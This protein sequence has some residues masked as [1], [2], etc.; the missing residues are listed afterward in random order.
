[1]H[2]GIRI[3]RVSRKCIKPSS[4][5]KAGSG[6]REYQVVADGSVPCIHVPILTFLKQ[7]MLYCIMELF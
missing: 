4:L 7:S 3:W 6:R 2:E 1:M 5:F